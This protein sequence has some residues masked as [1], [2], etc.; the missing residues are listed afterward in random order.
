MAS[1]L[2][3]CLLQLAKP[4]NIICFTCQTDPEWEVNL[5]LT[6]HVFCLKSELVYVNVDNLGGA[7]VSSGNESV[8]SFKKDQYS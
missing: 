6:M 3:V 7:R 4:I 8:G 1:F 2:C 5:C